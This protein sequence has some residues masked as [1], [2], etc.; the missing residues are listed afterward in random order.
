MQ[1]SDTINENACQTGET[2]AGTTQRYL[3][4]FDTATLP[5]ETADVL[6]I[7]SGVAGLTTAHFASQAGLSVLLVVR[8]TLF[9][10]NTNK[11][12]GG[13]A[14]ALGDD[15]NPTL[16]LQDTLIAGAG[17]TDENIAR[18]TVTEGP[19][20]ILNLIDNGALFDR[21]ADGSLNLGREGCHCRNRIVHAQ[22]DA[23]GAEVARALNAVVAKDEHVRP[24]EHCYVIDLLTRDGHC[25]GAIAMNNGGLVCLRAKA[26]VLATGGIGRL[27]LHTTNPE[28]ATGSGMALAYRAG[29]EMMDMEFVQFHPTA[30]A[31]KGLPNFLL[32]EAMR[33]AGA[34]LR[35]NKGERFMPKYHKMAELAPRDVVARCIFKEMQQDKADHIWL[36]ATQVEGVEKMFP[37]I[38]DTCKEYGID[39]SKEMIPIAPAA[40]YMMGGVRTDADGHTNIDGLY[41]V[42][43]TACTGLQGANRL[44]SNSLLEGL[45]FGRRT[46]LAI[47]QDSE[48]LPL[49]LGQQWKNEGL[50]P[51]QDDDTDLQT[52]RLQQIM[53]TYLGIRRDKEGMTQALK[54]IDELA[55]RYDGCSATQYPMLDLRARITVAGLVTR[56]ALEREESRGAHYRSDFPETKNEWKR[57]SIISKATATTL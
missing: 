53:S 28:G 21:K 7:G 48:H 16:H 24:M 31:I 41:A 56:S 26:T 55:R 23:T 36:D 13:I 44:A 8:D 47:R 45:V 19:K 9:D 18:I 1:K 12:Q 22:G 39:I 49:D 14:S 6:V 30:L 29:A 52:Q 27:F 35:N 42:G 2:E 17:L 15:D 50:R 4:N 54:E 3:T 37:M 25:H 32:S 5:Q 34:V 57:H 46:A 11:A 43:E 20:A 51:A 33:G 38:A 40:H 10:S